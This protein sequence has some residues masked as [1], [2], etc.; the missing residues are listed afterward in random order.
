MHTDTSTA[1]RRRITTPDRIRTITMMS[2]AIRPAGI[3]MNMAPTTRMQASVRSK[4]RRAG[5]VTRT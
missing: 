2:A 1:K 5:G 4:P 3:A